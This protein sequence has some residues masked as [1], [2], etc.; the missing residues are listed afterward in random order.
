[1]T[2]AR[3]KQLFSFCSVIITSRHRVFCIPNAI[4]SFEFYIVQST[5]IICHIKIRVT[6]LLMLNINPAAIIVS[7]TVWTFATMNNVQYV[8]MFILHNNYTAF[9]LILVPCSI[10]WSSDYSVHTQILVIVLVK[11]KKMFIICHTK[12][13]QGHSMFTVCIV[14][15]ILN[16]LFHVHVSIPLNLHDQNIF[17][18]V[19][20]IMPSF[21]W[22][23]SHVNRTLPRK[24]R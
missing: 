7:S 9:V 3:S 11:Y 16:A 23:H 18:G 2:T 4:T 6:I 21:Q 1:M 8:V 14:Y 10:Q 20:K 22:C 24:L 13:W 19:P 12:L 5:V 17:N 15:I